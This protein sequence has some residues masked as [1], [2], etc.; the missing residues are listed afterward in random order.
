[1]RLNE[2]LGIEFP[3]IQGGMANIATAE[4][5]AAVSNAGALGLIGAGGM[6]PEVFQDSIRRCRT[7]TENPFGVNIMLMHP[8]V[9]Q[10]AAIAAQE[11]VAV[12]TTGA[13]DPARFI[14][15]WKESGAKVFPVVPAVALAKVVARAGADAVIAEGTESGGHVGELTTMA[16]VPQV[17]DAVDIPVIAAGGIADGRQLLAAREGRVFLCYFDETAGRYYACASDVVSV[18]RL[19]EVVETLRDNGA[20]FAF[21]TEEYGGLEPYTLI[22]EKSLSPAVYASVDPL[23][24]SQSLSGLQEAL[25]FPESSASF[26]GAG[27][28]VIRSRNDTLRIGADGTV[29]YEPAAEGSDRYLLSG[30]GV[31]EAVEGCRD[32]A[33]QAVDAVGGEER[34]FL[35]SARETG[36]GGWE[37]QFGYSLD[38]VQVR[39]GEDGWAA[40]FTVEQ[41]QITG[42]QLRM[43][44]Y[45]DTGTTTVVLPE[46]QAMAAMEAKGHENEELLLVYLDT[47]AEMVTASWAAASELSGRG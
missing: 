44:C 46:R 42:F 32:L 20:R 34:L 3:F 12:V 2:L 33:Q 25:G 30:G 41:G 35:M 43:R 29:T 36:Q 37:I 9:E 16:L 15:A 31:Y 18:N 19:E 39:L 1:M 38:G 6:S 5:A 40:R 10:L 8:Q 45:T 28:Q 11:K 47:G 17:A 22:L 26:S 21:E 24:G 7:L 14:P 27:E 4:F 23:G 13:G